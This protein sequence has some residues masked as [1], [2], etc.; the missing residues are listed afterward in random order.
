MYSRCAISDTFGVPYRRCNLP[1][2]SGKN[3]SSPA[4]NGN[5]STEE[6]YPPDA[7]IMLIAMSTAAIGITLTH[8]NLSAVRVIACIRPCKSCTS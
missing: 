3:L 6:E 4:T 7:P 2:D 5:R 1:T 8:P